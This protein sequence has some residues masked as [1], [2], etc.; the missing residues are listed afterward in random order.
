MDT[1]WIHVD[2]PTVVLAPVA[3][4]AAFPAMRVLQI[5]FCPKGK[6]FDAEIQE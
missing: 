2:A 6:G 1:F 4:A 3:L 5:I